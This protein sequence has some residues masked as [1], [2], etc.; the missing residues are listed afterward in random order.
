M[1]S[2]VKPIWY[3]QQ[4]VQITFSMTFPWTRS[5]LR[6]RSASLRP[7]LTSKYTWTMFSSS[8]QPQTKQKLWSRSR[9]LACN[10][11]RLWIL[12]SGIWASLLHSKMIWLNPK[13]R[14]SRNSFSPS[15]PAFT[16]NPWSMR[17]A[18]AEKL[19]RLVSYLTKNFANSFPTDQTKKKL[20]VSHRSSQEVSKAK[21]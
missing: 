15:V 17:N 8:A 1:I 13:C 20:K 19:A 5:W 21:S 10:L 14:K 3:L 9:L 4:R 12:M 11:Y 7:T 2:M 16:I 6:R 18:A